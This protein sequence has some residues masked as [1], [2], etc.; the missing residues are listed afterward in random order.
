MRDKK[1]R[2]AETPEAGVVP[3]T[4]ILIGAVLIVVVKHFLLDGNTPFYS[5][6]RDGLAGFQSDNIEEE[7]ETIGSVD[8]TIYPKTKAQS[9]EFSF[10]V[11]QSTPVEADQGDD[12]KG[13]AQDDKK[14]SLPPKPLKY[15]APQTGGE[16]MRIAIII[17]DVGMNAKYS[18]AVMTDLPPEITLALLPYAPDIKAFAKKAK[19]R[20]HELMI[21]VPMQATRKMNLGPNGIT[22][23]MDRA[24]IRA[25]LEQ[26][27]EAFEGYT[28]INNHMGSAVTQDAE[29]M[30]WIIEELK[31]RDLFFVDS[32]TIQSSIAAKTAKRYG[33][34][35]ASRH[36]FL[37]HNEDRASVD[38][39]LRQLE[40][41]AARH[42]S[43]IAIGHPKKNTVDGLK[44]WIKTIEAKNIELVPISDLLF[45]PTGEVIED[46][47]PKLPVIKG[48]IDIEEL[49]S[50]DEIADAIDG[51]EGDVSG[52]NLVPLYHK[53]DF[54]LDLLMHNEELGAEGVAVKPSHS[55][56]LAP[57]Q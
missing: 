15:K 21:H 33:I 50:V 56:G 41:Y 39:S 51:D 13:N 17:D 8:P 38:A 1:R 16:T 52:E 10:F 46:A 3:L 28:G 19:V 4:Y 32:K 18:R 36:V 25:S 35:Y 11:P 47:V 6:I 2:E 44:N 37:D 42:G 26:S 29:R 12:Q 49:V 22:T 31:A 27:F 55:H 48:D 54:V 24:A 34:P 40:R 5:Q 9:D 57:A 30:S 14:T 7:L 43:A 45:Y 23:S 20:G 53:P